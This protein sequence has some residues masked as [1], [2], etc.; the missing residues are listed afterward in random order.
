MMN[1]TTAAPQAS[2]QPPPIPLSSTNL[3]TRF[4]EVSDAKVGRLKGGS[5]EVVQGDAVPL[6]AT[7]SFHYLHHLPA[8]TWAANGAGVSVH[9]TPGETLFYIDEGG[10]VR[11]P[12]LPID[13]DAVARFLD[14]NYS[15]DFTIKTSSGR[16]APPLPD[17]ILHKTSVEWVRVLETAG[18]QSDLVE[19][20]V[21]VEPT[22]SV[23]LELAKPKETWTAIVD[24]LAQMEQVL[25]RLP[26]D[27]AAAQQAALAAL[28]SQIATAITGAEATLQQAITSAITGAE[29]TLQQAITSA[30]TG[31]E[32][33]ILGPVSSNEESAKGVPART[34]AM[35]LPEI[36]PAIS[37][38]DANVH[39]L[40]S[41]A[42]T[43][44]EKLGKIDQMEQVVAQLAV[45]REFEWAPMRELLES[46]QQDLTSKR[47]PSKADHG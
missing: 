17:S 22:S 9:V 6:V 38:T 23:R 21:R 37:S 42:A 8:A 4:L 40:L 31:A 39:K 46:V 29:A 41:S 7:A 16:S 13:P 44:L 27:V 18:L 47:R 10:E 34:A 25:R 12:R 26:G 32:S 1:T 24:S 30:I 33:L 5:A 28:E 14:A 20:D 11:S 43:V 2:P 36:S 15:F 35:M 19:I 3:E 45:L